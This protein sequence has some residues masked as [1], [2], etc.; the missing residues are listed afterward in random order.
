MNEEMRKK[1]EEKI[2]KLTKIQDEMLKLFNDL[3]QLFLDYQKV[4][5]M[6]I[7]DLDLIEWYKEYVK[8]YKN[9]N[10]LINNFDDLFNRLTDM[11]IL[12]SKDVIGKDD[13]NQ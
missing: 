9:I 13:L 6:I 8:Q 10:E 11:K 3:N 1:Y 5:G 12:K 4:E 7:N 2:E